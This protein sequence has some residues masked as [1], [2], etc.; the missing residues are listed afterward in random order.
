MWQLR[1]SYQLINYCKKKYSFDYLKEKYPFIAYELERQ[2]L[3][4]VDK[5]AYIMGV[6]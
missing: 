6:R 4:E 1:R 3:V 2:G 5:I